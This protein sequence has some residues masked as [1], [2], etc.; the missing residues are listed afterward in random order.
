LEVVM[1]IG[2]TAA[3]LIRR[4][5]E[6]HRKAQAEQARREA[7]QAAKRSEFQSRIF[8]RA[9]ETFDRCLAEARAAAD[10]RGRYAELQLHAGRYDASDFADRVNE[11]QMAVIALREQGLKAEYVVREDVE[12]DEFAGGN[13]VVFAPLIEMSWIH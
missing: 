8:E 12:Y 7:D 2:V 5:D 1:G 3:E 13:R 4:S 10:K 6:A 9:R 11:W